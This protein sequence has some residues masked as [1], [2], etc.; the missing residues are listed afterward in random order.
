MVGSEGAWTDIPDRDF[1]RSPRSLDGANTQS[2]MVYVDD[3]SA[4][5]AP[6][7]AHDASIVKDLAVSEYGEEYWADQ[8]Y[9]YEDI[10]GHTWHF[11]QRLRT[12]GA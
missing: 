1:A 4:H 3:V 8:G 2:L 5:L 9:A 6:A 12:K 7:K 11:A 10:E